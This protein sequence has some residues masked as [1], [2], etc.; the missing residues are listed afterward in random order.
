MKNPY[1]FAAMM[2]KR[3]YAD[4]EVA[5]I[6]A[7]YP[8]VLSPAL[9]VIGAEKDGVVSGIYFIQYQNK[10]YFLTDC[11][12]NTHPNVE[13]LADIVMNGVE[14]MERFG[15]EP[16]VAMMSYS[17]FGSVR[18]EETKKIEKTIDLVLQK[19]PDL[20]I[21]GPIQA[22]IALDLEKM[23]ELYPFSKL[24]ERPNLLV[25]PDLNSGNISLKLIQHFSKANIIGPIMEGF[26]KPVHLV[27]RSSDVNNIVNLT[28][29][30]NV[31]AQ[32]K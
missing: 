29:I 4:A 23:T 6:N 32:A 22:N 27:T 5:G 16:R 28:A 25:F 24:K 2:V 20:M 15:F 13:E 11:A 3:G 7:N 14:A 10:A 31:D 21:D 1:F 9:K 17:N 30:S 18:D 12:V 8:L 19:R 26:N